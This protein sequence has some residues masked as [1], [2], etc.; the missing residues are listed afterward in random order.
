MVKD[1]RKDTIKSINKRHI[2]KDLG[3]LGEHKALLSDDE[4]HVT[5]LPNDPRRQ[6]NMTNKWDE[7]DYYNRDEDHFFIYIV[8]SDLTYHIKAG[9]KADDVDQFLKRKGLNKKQ[10]KD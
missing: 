8:K 9:E 7:F 3:V 6:R 10:Q 5:Y 4:L 2:S 1:N